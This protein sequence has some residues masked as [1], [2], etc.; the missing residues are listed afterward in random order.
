ME[1]NRL[2][3]AIHPPPRCCGTDMTLEGNLSV[4]ELSY[5]CDICFALLRARVEFAA[6]PQ[7]VTPKEWAGVLADVDDTP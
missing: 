4:H 7:K 3:H 2:F 6:G 5:K 1:T